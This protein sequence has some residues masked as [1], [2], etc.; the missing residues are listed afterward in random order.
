MYYKGAFIS[1]GAFYI[2]LKTIGMIF[3]F[4]MLA[5]ATENSLNLDSEIARLRKEVSRTQNERRQI[6]LGMAKDLQESTAYRSRT[7]AQFIQMRKQMDS[8]SSETHVLTKKRDSL[9]ALIRITQSERTQIELSQDRIRTVL[10][11]ECAKVATLVQT[12]PPLI[13]QHLSSSLEL[14][15][16]DISTK[17]V[18]NNESMTRLLQILDRMED[19]TASIQISQENSPVSDIRGTVY[20]VRFGTVFEG[21]V[22][23]KGEKAVVWNGYNTSK[24][25]IWNMGESSAATA[26]LKAAEIREGKALPGFVL[27]PFIIDSTSGKGAMQ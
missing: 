9:D 15:V 6:Q 18:D 8:I 7:D 5:A 2:V 13:S 16:A 11:N 22:D 14:L 10:L 25:P 4:Y 3:Y 20:R 23:V 27:I 26:L 12:F 19:A 24:A 17:S 1:R 21:V